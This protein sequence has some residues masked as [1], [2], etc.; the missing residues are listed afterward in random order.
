MT[1]SPWDRFASSYARQ[2][3]LERAALRALLDLL[4]IRRDERLLDVATGPGVLL[5]ELAR[6]EVRPHA[7]VGV[8]SSV[9]MLGHAPPLPVGWSLEQGDAA[10]LPYP[11]ESFD[12]VVA[13]Y[14]LHVMDESE[15]RAAVA[16]MARVVRSG[17]R[18]GTITITPPRSPWM[19]ALTAPLRAHARRS[20]GRLRGFRSLDPSVELEA[21]GLRIVAQARSF[22]GYPSLCIVSERDS[23]A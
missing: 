7:A 15:R 13:G 2:V 10:C 14:L 8:D 16:E 17:G 3:F 23:T 20:E 12:V 9:E 6:R 19:T 11:D 5:A 22:R 18:V 1:E 21:A 4:R